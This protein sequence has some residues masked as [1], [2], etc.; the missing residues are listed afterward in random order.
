MICDIDFVGYSDTPAKGLSLRAFAEALIAKGHDRCNIAEMLAD[1]P[2]RAPKSGTEKLADTG[3]ASMEHQVLGPLAPGDRL[4]HPS[5]QLV[6]VIGRDPGDFDQVICAQFNRNSKE[7]VVSIDELQPVPDPGEAVWQFTVMGGGGRLVRLI[8]FPALVEAELEEAWQAGA[9][10]VAQPSIDEPGWATVPFELHNSDIAR[11]ES[12][13]ADLSQM[14]VVSSVGG[15][16]RNIVRTEKN[17]SMLFPLSLVELEA[18]WTSKSLVQVKGK[19]RG[20][21]LFVSADNAKIEL[22]PSGRKTFCPLET[23]YSADADLDVLAAWTNR[24][25]DF[26]SMVPVAMPDAAVAPRR[27]EQAPLTPEMAEQYR[28]DRSRSQ[29][30]Y[31]PGTQWSAFPATTSEKLDDLFSEPPSEATIDQRPCLLLGTYRAKVIVGTAPDTLTGTSAVLS[32]TP[33]LTNIHTHIHQHIY[34]L[35]SM[36]Y[37]TPHMCARAHAHHVVVNAC[38]SSP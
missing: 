16:K 4:F 32:R 3:A 19:G 31:K 17:G 29:W 13:T 15:F 23:I 28:S 7:I 20:R 24:S 22:D 35:A 33:P 1:A 10:W 18:A 36:S 14:V 37:Y 27:F 8:R 34:L 9:G 2:T 5:Y 11:H 21:L 25:F 6:T 12:C 30:Q 26:R 38:W